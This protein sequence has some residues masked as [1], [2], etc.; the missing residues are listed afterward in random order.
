MFAVCR[1]LIGF[2]LGGTMSA[3]IT[4]ACESFLSKDRTLLYLG[5]WPLGYM[6]LALLAMVFTNWRTLLIAGE[7][8]HKYCAIV[9]T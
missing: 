3:E 8:T 7:E 4:W 1:F 2:G 5:G 9:K 6:L